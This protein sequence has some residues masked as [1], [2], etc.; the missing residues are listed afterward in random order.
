M[1]RARKETPRIPKLAGWGRRG[2]VRRGRT[3]VQSR[4]V[5]C[6]AS[7]ITASWGAARSAEAMAHVDPGQDRSTR[8]NPCPR[9]EG[10]AHRWRGPGDAARHAQHAVRGADLGQMGR[11]V[12]TD[13]AISRSGEWGSRGMARGRPHAAAGET[14]GVPGGVRDPRLRCRS[15]GGFRAFQEVRKFRETLPF[16][17]APITEARSFT[18]GS[19]APPRRASCRW[20][21]SSRR[22]PSS[23]GASSS[24]SSATR[25]SSTYL[26]RGLKLSRGWPIYRRAAAWLVQRFPEVLEP[27]REGKLCFTTAAGWPRWRRRRT[28]PRCF[29]DSTACPAGVPELAAA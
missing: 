23:T 14:S 18:P 3:T 15:S 24:A 11:G 16:M 8:T 22:S 29:R 9:W 12:D 4:L 25:D 27:I 20:A 2:P 28:W 26:H 13:S 19:R 17:N 21:P 7:Q 10:M 1:P 6:S 5:G